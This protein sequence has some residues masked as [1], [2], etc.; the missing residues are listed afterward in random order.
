ML[1]IVSDTCPRFVFAENVSEKAIVASA[2][3]L[4]NIGYVCNYI[5]LSAKDL[6]ADH[7]RSRFW[8]LAYSDHDGKF[9]GTVNAETQML[10]KFCGSVWA[11]F[12]GELRVPDGLAFRLDRLKALGNGQVP[13]VAA[14]A[15]I[16]L[17]LIS[18]GKYKEG[19]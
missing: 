6:G 19:A 1:R 13:I 11:T 5:Q 15:W 3:D 14:I 9:C 4:S 8:L 17:Y 16:K 18:F 12:A 2:N 10:Q 7:E